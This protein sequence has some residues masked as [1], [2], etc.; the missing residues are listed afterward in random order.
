MGKPSWFSSATCKTEYA[1][2]TCAAPLTALLTSEMVFSS[3]ILSPSTWRSRAFSIRSWALPCSDAAS[4]L[5]ALLA[6]ATAVPAGQG[7]TLSV[8]DMY[9]QVG[10]RG[11]QL[12]TWTTR[13]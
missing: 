3:A 13:G 9:H 10:V 11:A 8:P 4:L 1:S 6:L 2:A 5:S 12:C 7:L